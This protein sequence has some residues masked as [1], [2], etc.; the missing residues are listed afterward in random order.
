MLSLTYFIFRFVVCNAIKS[1]KGVVCFLLLVSHI[2]HLFFNTLA[3]DGI[4]VICPLL[5]YRFTSWNLLFCYIW[6]F[7]SDCRSIRDQA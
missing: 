7:S 5:L 6:Y 1:V 3:Q 4:H 2:S